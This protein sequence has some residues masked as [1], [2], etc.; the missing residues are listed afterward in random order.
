M[1]GH[2]KYIQFS[3]NMVQSP[4]ALQ[5][6]PIKPWVLS[7]PKLPIQ[8]FCYLLYMQSFVLLCGLAKQNGRIFILKAKFVTKCGQETISLIL[9]SSIGFLTASLR[10]PGRPHKRIHTQV[11]SSLMADVCAHV[12]IN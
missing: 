7:K 3:G 12:Q 10:Y 8:N 4:L 9:L 1:T 5:A 2:K 6:V 11:S